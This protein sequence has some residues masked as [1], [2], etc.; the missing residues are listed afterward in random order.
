MGKGAFREHF[1]S[2]PPVSYHDSYLYREG[3]M[4]EYDLSDMLDDWENRG[5]ELIE[6]KDGQKHWKEVCVAYSGHGPSYPCGWL[7]Y[8]KESN[9]V[10]LEGSEPGEIVGPGEDRD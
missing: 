8:D 9:S 7:E 3:C 4:N 2:V 6:V 10:W 5:F 1:P